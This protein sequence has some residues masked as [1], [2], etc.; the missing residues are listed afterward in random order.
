MS[1]R[2]RS[3]AA[4]LV[5]RWA[6]TGPLPSVAV[7]MLV[8]AAALVAVV[9]PRA[10]AD[11]HTASLARQLAERPAS[12]LDLTATSPFGPDSGPSTSGT[13]LPD[14]VDAVWGGQEERLAGIR[15]AL[16][17]PL[18]STTD[19]PMS[20]AV[21]GPV[22][23]R[24]PGA[25]PG[26]PVYRIEPGFDPRMREHVRLVEG[27]WP[28]PLPGPLAESQAEAAE[29]VLAAPV[30]EAMRWQVG[31]ERTVDEAGLR[32]VVRLAGIVEAVD[33]D[34]G[35]WTHL[36]TALRASV[37]DNGV[38]PPQ[39]TAVAWFDP[40]SWPDFAEVALALRMD[41]WIPV[42]ASAI[43]AADADRIAGQ[44]GEFSS[45]SQVLGSGRSV[46][47]TIAGAAPGTVIP[48][49]SYS[50]VGVVG[51]TTGLRDAL[52][53]MTTAAASV[54]AVLA[55]VASGPLGVAV[56]VLVLGARVVFERRRT[57]LELAAA[58]GASPAQLR[59]V[60]LAEGLV[61]GI[62]AGAAG[63]ALAIA[64]TPGSTGL[65]GWW[66]AAVLA[67]TPAV[68]L[69]ARAGELSPLRRARADLGG[70]A[71][72]RW[73]VVVEA[74]VV[75]VGAASVAL[76]LQRGT[77]GAAEVGVDPLLAA[78]P[79]LLALAACVL[80]LRLYP[81]PLAALVRRMSRRRDL[82]PFLGS[83]R[84][85]RDPSAGLVPVLAVVV[86]VS[87]AVTSAVV[88][89]TLDTGIDV[90]SDRR[91][92][93]DLAVSG[94]PITRAQLAEMREA[95]GVEAIAPVYSTRP[96][97][98]EVDGR[99][100]ATTLIVVD[101]AEL[102]AVQQGREDALVLPAELAETGAD[103][104]P[105][106]V[107]RSVGEAIAD[108]PDVS[109]EGRGIRI[110]AT[111][112]AQSPFTPRS[113]WVLVDRAN[114]EPFTDT[115]VPRNVLVRLDPGADPDEVGAALTA[116]AGDG[117]TAATPAGLAA[118]IRAL[119]DSQGLR[120]GLLAGIAAATVLTALALALTL[121]V[122]QSARAR[123]LPLLATL[124]LGR[125]G[126]QA[127]VAWE[128][129]PVTAVAVLAGVALGAIV[130]VVVLQGVDLRAFTGGSTP[131]A[132]TYD[133]ALIGAVV[134]ASVAVSAVAAG[135]ASHVGGRVSAARA[136]RKEEEG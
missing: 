50:T 48:Y 120:I 101:R 77:S 9:A 36:P 65:A 105:V 15:D 17:E 71:G 94:V 54:D 136:M 81:L 109:L 110:A 83:A 56:A 40:A 67:V 90:A 53:E 104:A 121:L 100:R 42:D 29:I 129:A 106:V 11:I 72:G 87:V 118:G 122:G 32:A 92:G 34:A 98:L 63:A 49:I 46:E 55:T 47:V 8:L 126:E 69:V 10:V 19:A 85:L 75:I 13:T 45:T 6:S 26:S 124:G 95:D 37:V 86:G 91:V 25:G 74:L 107:S 117:A 131:P 30:A 44:L 132:V 1:R 78:A 80:V 119:P 5:L 113:A 14:D 20:V 33:P 88:L 57:G 58:R 116:I 60:L 16:P 3:S 21:S 41:A 112:D 99:S 111:V 12:E 43:D 35:F 27:D 4:G 62:P 123:L 79:L 59:T 68:L 127:L 70:T 96:A 2:S 38:S 108:A 103:P 128:I 102:A 24:V 82:V 114:A 61:L 115:L 125:R 135:I 22:Q 93:A 52:V 76:L 134:I 31:D 18:R 7:A 133:W 51:F 130:P 23:A 64:L 89:A 28:A 66:I 39:Y 84:A 97:L 73:R